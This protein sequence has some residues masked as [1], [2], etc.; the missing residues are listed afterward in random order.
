MKTLELRVPPVVQFLIAATGMWLISTLTPQLEFFLP[1]RSVISG[2]IVI[3]AL[4]PAGAG[5]LAFKQAHTSTNPVNPDA[6]TSVVTTGI[7]AFTRNPM[8]LGLA[9][10]LLSNAIMLSHAL[11]FVFVP[12]F[13]LYITHYQIKPEERVLTQKFGEAYQTYQKNVRRWI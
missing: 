6:A 8:Y 10:L 4:I 2:I 7:Y 12:A 13:M 5:I 3:L 1:A 9:L 11:A